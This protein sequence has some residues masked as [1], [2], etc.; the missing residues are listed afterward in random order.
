M[1][2]LWR[3]IC[4]VWKAITQASTVTWL[5]SLLPSSVIS[6]GLASLAWTENQPAAIISA[7]LI[8]VFG[9]IFLCTLAYLSYHF[10]YRHPKA[11]GDAKSAMLVV[12]PPTLGGNAA[13]VEIRLTAVR[14]LYSIVNGPVREALEYGSGII[15]SMQG[16]VRDH[17]MT[18]FLNS[19]D[20]FRIQLNA[21]RAF[22][23]QVAS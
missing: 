12:S 19:L 7:I 16:I 21:A 13:E 5:L 4:L 22:F 20:T 18:G 14:E 10:P 8:V 23:V 9:I 11:G 15:D 6:I 17:Y 3:L 2:H 1:H